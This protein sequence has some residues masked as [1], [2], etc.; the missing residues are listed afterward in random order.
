M[1]FLKRHRFFLIFLGVLVFCSIM[2]VRQFLINQWEHNDLR[3]D[4][5]LLHD[6]GK[7]KTMER[8]YQMLI[9]E[10]PALPDRALLDDEQRLNLFLAS[11][12]LPPT[13]LLWK[14]HVSVQNE[15]QRRVNSRVTRAL[16]RAGGE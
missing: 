10:L 3:E 5:I 15:L 16:K 8:L 11:K 13:D 6:E 2:V 4:F 12:N 7:T 9:Q 1:R 14:Y